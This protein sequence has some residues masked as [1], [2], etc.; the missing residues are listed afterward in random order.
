MPE[1]MTA[2]GE[3]GW[4]EAASAVSGHSQAPSLHPSLAGACP[5]TAA[6]P[7]PPHTFRARARSAAPSRACQPVAGPLLLPLPG[8]QVSEAC[9]VVTIG[10]GDDTDYWDFQHRSVTARSQPVQTL[11]LFAAPHS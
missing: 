1:G 5:S 3:G 6:P 9:S 11:L 8:T 7:S 2:G 4:D 10:A